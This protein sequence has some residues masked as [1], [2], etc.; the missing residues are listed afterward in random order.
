MKPVTHH[1]LTSGLDW[2][3]CN[4]AQHLRSVI[5]SANDSWDEI[6]YRRTLETFDEKDD[7]PVLSQGPGRE[8]DGIWYV[9]LH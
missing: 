4:A 9:W 3:Y 5:M 7:S 1:L 2:P 8:T 6:A